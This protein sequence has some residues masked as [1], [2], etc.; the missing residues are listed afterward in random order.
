MAFASAK[1]SFLL[2]ESRQF[3]RIG[4]VARQTVTAAKLRL[5]D[6][7]FKHSP[8]SE[9]LFYLGDQ[10]R[11]IFHISEIIRMK[12]LIR[13]ELARMRREII[14]VYNIQSA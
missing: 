8:F 3:L 12:S 4:S 10:L 6:L 7:P 13:I 14:A 5:K 11:R 2:A 9:F 1:A